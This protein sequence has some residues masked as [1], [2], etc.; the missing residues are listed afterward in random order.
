ML[1]KNHGVTGGMLFTMKTVV[2]VVLSLVV[3]CDQLGGGKAQI[4]EYIEVEGTCL[5][6]HA[7]LTETQPYVY[8]GI[9]THFAYV[10]RDAH[11][12]Y[13]FVDLQI[14]TDILEKVPETDYRPPNT[15][16]LLGLS[17]ELIAQDSFQAKGRSDRES[18]GERRPLFGANCTLKVTKRLDY[19][20][21]TE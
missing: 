2:L 1:R 19:I 17:K 8:S 6:E 14:S 7:T 13:G 12:I 3:G 9:I 11:E 21:S 5:E 10:T 20:P 18:D 15:I 16:Y 4:I